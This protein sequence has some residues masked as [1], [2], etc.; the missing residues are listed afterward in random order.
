MN[1]S[2]V[3]YRDIAMIIHS[4]DGRYGHMPQCNERCDESGHWLQQSVPAP[5]QVQHE[6]GKEPESAT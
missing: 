5:W 2:Q 4:D 1:D 3:P 6:Q